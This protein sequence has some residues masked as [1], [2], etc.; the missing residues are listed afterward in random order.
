MS[1][2]EISAEQVHTGHVLRGLEIVDSVYTPL[3]SN[4]DILFVKYKMYDGGR[5]FGRFLAISPS[6]MVQVRA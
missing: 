6:E 3:G 1:W 5:L 2:T 4:H